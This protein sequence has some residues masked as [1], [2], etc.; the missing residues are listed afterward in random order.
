MAKSAF[1][2][3]PFVFRK[4]FETSRQIFRLFS[5]SGSEWIKLLFLAVE[6]VNS[7]VSRSRDETSGGLKIVA[8]VVPRSVPQCPPEDAPSQHF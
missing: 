5:E 2:P 8:K 7:G 3:T 4:E 1:K 6:D